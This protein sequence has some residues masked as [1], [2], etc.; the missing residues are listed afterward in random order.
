MRAVRLVPRWSYQAEDQGRSGKR[1]TRPEAQDAESS[2]RGPREP[3]LVAAGTTPNITYENECRGRFQLDA[4]KKFFQPHALSSNGDGRFHL[5]PDPLGFFTSYDAGREVRDL[6][7][8]Q[9]SALR[10]PTSSKRMA[11]AKDG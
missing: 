9:P 4:K 7:R 8:R 1:R 5:T 3:C 6:L 11:S 2:K 10:R